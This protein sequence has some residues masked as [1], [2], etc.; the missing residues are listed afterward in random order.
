MLVLGLA[1]S[2]CSIMA[3]TVSIGWPRAG[4][5][6]E[7]EEKEALSFYPLMAGPK[8]SFLPS[9]PPHGWGLSGGVKKDS[10]KG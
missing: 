8:D 6:P 5:I 2:R 9:P 4:R 7:W 10:G 3:A 1:H